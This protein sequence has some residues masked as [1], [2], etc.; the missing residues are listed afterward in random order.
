MMCR[1]ATI[2]VMALV[3]AGCYDGPPSSTTIVGPGMTPV[4]VAGRWT[5]SASDST[6]QLSMTWVLTQQDRTVTGTFQAS[7]PVGAPVYTG[8][9]ISGTALASGLTFTITVPRGSVVDFPDCTALFA[10]TADDVRTDSMAG[11]YSGSD[12]CGGTYTGGRFTLIK[13]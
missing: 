6:R 3:A 12:T 1:V 10:G 9:T 11:T 5:G 8:G 4:N 7:T 2:A 13:E